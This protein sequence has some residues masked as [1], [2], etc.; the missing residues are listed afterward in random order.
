MIRFMRSR[1]YVQNK[2]FEALKYAQQAALL[3]AEIM[4]QAKFRV[5]T[6]RFSAAERIYWIADF[7]G[8][9][10]LEQVL[11][12]IETDHRWEAF[13]QKAPAGLFIE[14]SGEESVLVLET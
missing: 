11:Q 7:E 4:P 13:R 12:E 1:K 14:G 8:L 5:F 9:V 3:A 6:G 2:K 10:A